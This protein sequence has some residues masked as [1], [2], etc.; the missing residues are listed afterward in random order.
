MG[1]HSTCRRPGSNRRRHH[2]TGSIASAP[3]V[4]LCV[5]QRYAAGG[6]HA[7]HPPHEVA[8]LCRHEGRALELARGDSTAQILAG[9]AVEGEVTTHH[10]IQ[11]NAQTPHIHSWWIIRLSRH[12]LR[13]RIRRRAAS[14]FKLL[15]VKESNAESKICKFDISNSVQEKIIQLHI[16]DAYNQK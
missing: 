13:C 9:V 16:S 10:G 4:L 6:I 3:A 11:H 14:L 1:Q 15:S 12:N 7:E 2:T 8:T 5:S